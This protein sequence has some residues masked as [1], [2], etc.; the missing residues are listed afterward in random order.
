[1]FGTPDEV[2]TKLRAYEELGVDFLYCASY[3][4]AIADQKRSLQLFIDEVMPAFA[5][6][7]G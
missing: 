2:I 6:S 4:A 5:E 1:M 7:T 3:G